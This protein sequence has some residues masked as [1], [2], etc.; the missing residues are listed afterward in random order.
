MYKIYKLIDNTNNNVYIGQTK[1]LK[2]RIY[3][4]NYHYKNP[5]K[6][7]RLCSSTEIFKNN[8]WTFQLIEETDDKSREIYWIKNTRNCINK[9]QYN[10]SK[11]ERDKLFHINN[12]D[13][14]KKRY[15]YFKSW[16]GD[17]RTNN[18]LLMIDTNLFK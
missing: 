7:Q 8:D 14:D 4:H 1:D 3:N 10:K 12:P 13:Y 16:G 2:Q 6:V 9:L 18:N 5:E 15:E 11:K 17:K